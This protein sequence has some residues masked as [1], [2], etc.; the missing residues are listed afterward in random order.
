MQEISV[1]QCSGIRVYNSALQSEI[2][3]ENNRNGRYKDHAH[4]QPSDDSYSNK[5]NYQDMDKSYWHSTYIHNSDIHTTPANTFDSLHDCNSN[6]NNARINRYI[7]NTYISLG[8][9]NFIDS[10]G[11]LNVTLNAKKS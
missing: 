7:R 5:A 1:F 9:C 4:N 10:A 3:I 6:Y 2:W 8:L 11:S